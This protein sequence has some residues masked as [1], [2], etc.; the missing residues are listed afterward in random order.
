MKPEAKKPSE[1]AG[2]NLGVLFTGYAEKQ[3]PVSGVYKKRFLVLTQESLHWFIRT[4]GY[5]LFGEEKGHVCL[6][7]VIAVRVLDED[8]CIFEVKSENEKRRLYRCASSANCSEWVSAMRSAIKALG[9]KRRTTRRATLSNFRSLYEEPDDANDG[10]PTVDVSILLV[11]IRSKMDNT[12]V[13]VARNPEWNHIIFLSHLRKG[14][15]LVISTSNGGVATLTWDTL[16]S[17]ADEN[18]EF[19]Q[20]VQEVTLASSIRM[21]LDMIDA[22]GVSSSGD[23]PSPTNGSRSKNSDLV[24]TVWNL[25]SQDRRHTVT[26]MLSMMTIMI[27]FSNLG[28]ITSESALLI[29]FT[30]LVTLQCMSYVLCGNS[31][32]RSF[33]ILNLLSDVSPTCAC[34]LKA[35]KTVRMSLF[36]IAHAFTSPDAPVHSPEDDIPQRFVDGCMGDLKEARRRWDITRKWRETEVHQFECLFIYYYSIILLFYYSYIHFFDALNDPI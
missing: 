12:E 23:S 14:D 7:D 9:G 34:G 6:S 5:D 25:L 8:S 30:I 4:E 28:Y 36:L 18:M 29:I 22:N 17:R 21:K 13:V 35:T 27:L 10:E 33:G 20:P 26:L 19:D 2:R 32:G 3:N 11:S 31:H 15:E 24:A 1:E 16:I